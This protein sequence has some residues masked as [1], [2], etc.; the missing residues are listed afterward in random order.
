MGNGTPIICLLG[1]GSV[2]HLR[3]IGPSGIKGMLIGK[4]AS[5]AKRHGNSESGSNGRKFWMVA[6]NEID[7]FGA[8]P[9][10]KSCGQS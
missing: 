10:E 9:R 4:I 5:Q 3:M 1:S 2:N 6:V 7:F 8:N